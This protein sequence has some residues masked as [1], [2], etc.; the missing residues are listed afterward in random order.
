[1]KIDRLFFEE[2]DRA[3]RLLGC[4]AMYITRFPEQLP[5]SLSVTAR[6]FSYVS[7]SQIFSRSLV[8]V[9]HG[10]VGTVA[11]ALRSGRPQLVVPRAHDQFDNGARVEK[12]GA[13]LMLPYPRYKSGTVA[14]VLKKILDDKKMEATCAKVA[15]YFEPGVLEQTADLVE[16][17]N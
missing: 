4:R 17:L 7:F 1:M 9:N 12:L 11:Q 6:H 3:V 10:G 5:S 16:S 2:S 15:G 14:H 8:S 13:G